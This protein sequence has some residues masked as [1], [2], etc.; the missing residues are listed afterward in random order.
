MASTY[1]L[2]IQDEFT[3]LRGTPFLLAATDFEISA[4]WRRAGI[5]LEVV[6]DT[7]RSV[8]Q[9]RESGSRRVRGL[10]F[11]DRAV[12][13]AWSELGGAQAA[14]ERDVDDCL[15]GLAAEVRRAGLETGH[16]IADQIEA[17]QGSVA[18]REQ[19]LQELDR[20]LIDA[21]RRELGENWQ[22]SRQRQAERAL[23]ALKG[24][25]APEQFCAECRAWVDDSARELLQLPRLS[26]FG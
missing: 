13:K 24:R 7:M 21:A 5:P 10:K 20:S 14:E 23:A 16:S 2:S 4:A 15:P 26:L 19:R 8:L 12:W 17:V 6:L 1:F 11:I 9:G 3:R 22:I 25:I 18:E